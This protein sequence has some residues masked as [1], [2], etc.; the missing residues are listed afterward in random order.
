MALFETIFDV[1]YLISVVTIGIIII[2]KAKGNKEHTL[3]GAMAVILGCGDAFHLVPRVMSLWTENG[4]VKNVAALGIG[5]LVTSITMT[6]FYIILYFVWRERYH[7]KG[8]NSLTYT[9]LGLAALRII[10]CLL[11]Q[12]A[13][14][15]PDAP[16][17]FGILRNIPF[18]IMGIIIIV[19]FYKQAKLNSDKSFKNMWLAIALSFAFYAP[20]V[21]FA[22]IFP[23]VGALMM[24]KTLAYV[25]IV[26][27]GFNSLKE[28]NEK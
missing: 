6:I 10:F 8:Q 21:L 24:P 4:F 11:P 26:L 3:F 9:I 28:G 13:W 12:N 18:A 23:P 19:L 2:C 7:I 5:Q 22:Q 16:L 1:L 15:S 20:V 27:M 14:T 17:S 25:W